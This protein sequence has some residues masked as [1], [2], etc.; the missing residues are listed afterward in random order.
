MNE[1][2]PARI[3]RRAIILIAIAALCFVV[4]LLTPGIFFV[5][6]IVWIKVLAK[7][8]DALLVDPKK[9]QEEQRETAKW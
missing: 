6:D 8:N 7:Q 9:A 3:S 2:Q 5:V 1:A 4:C